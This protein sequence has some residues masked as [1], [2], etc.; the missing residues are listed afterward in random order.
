MHCRKSWARL[1]VAEK[2]AFI[3]AV[4]KLKND[5]AW[6]SVLHPGD[7]TRH[8][9]DDYV[10]LH[11][12]A[13]SLMPSWAHMAPAFFSWHRELMRHFEADLRTIDASVSIPYW[14]WS[15]FGGTGGPIFEADASSGLGTNGQAS[16]GKVLDG[17]FAFNAGQWTIRVKDASGNPSFLARRFGERADAPSLATIPN[18]QIAALNQGAYDAPPWDD[19]VAG[20][21]G[22]SLRI[23]VEYDLHNLVHRWLART[24]ILRSSPNDPIF[25]L[26]H[27]NIDRLWAVWQRQHPTLDPYLPASGAPTGHNAGDALIFHDATFPGVPWPGTVTSASVVNHHAISPGAYWYDDDPPDVVARTNSIAFTDIQEGVGGTP[28]TTY[29]AVVLEVVPGPCNAITLEIVAGPTAGLGTPLGTS[30]VIPASDD[31]TP[32]KGRLWISY[33]TSAGTIYGGS[34]A[35]QATSHNSAGDVVWTETWNVG[36]SANSVPH[37][38]S[39]VVLVLDRS[40]SMADDS[41][42]GQPKVTKLREA[43]AIFLDIMQEDDGI[44]IVRFDHE[45]DRLLDVTEVGPLPAVPGSGREAVASILASSN[46]AT[47]LDPRGATSVGGGVAEGRDALT[48]APVPAVP[49]GAFGLLVLTDGNENRPPSIDSVDMAGAVGADTFAIGFGTAG[50]VSEDALDKLTHHN[51]GYLLITGTI[52]QSERFLL[53]KYFLQ[54]QAGFTNAQIVADP[55]GELVLG[56]EH[57]IPFW[58]TEADAGADVLVLSVAPGLIDFTLETPSGDLIDPSTMVSEPAVSFFSRP[59]I[60][61]YRLTLPALGSAPGGSHGGQ[62]H[63][64]LRLDKRARDLDRETLA[65][66]G[67]GSLP[68]SVEVRAHSNLRFAVDA[69]QDDRQPGAMVKLQA[70][71]SEYDIPVEGRA[72]VWADV[73][74]PGG[75]VSTFTFDEVRG[76]QFEASF[77]TAKHGVYRILVRVRGTTLFGRTFTREQALSAS[78]FHKRDHRIDDDK[79]SEMTEKREDKRQTTPGEQPVL[80]PERPRSTRPE[81]R[82]DVDIQGIAELETPEPRSTTV[83][84]RMP[85][86]LFPTRAEMEANRGKHPMP[87]RRDDDD[88][89]G[90]GHDEG[91]H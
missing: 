72:R 8:R 25:W 82:G 52:T 62:W 9:Y 32:T 69:F 31:P 76:G 6:P 18:D 60:A 33:S 45:V 21:G 16:D 3:S 89:E 12:E 1:T 20:G 58:L 30:I 49:Y 39:A 83:R 24:M 2:Q 77:K 81:R 88:S 50:N 4:L 73:T 14:D 29:R 27:C 7:A 86:P 51:G 59:R 17:A 91:E 19:M 56:A 11:L 41:G 43:V 28:T 79:A 64:I 63:A 90:Q 10:E 26:H 61:W 46:P 48:S 35:V 5:A 84:E 15:L 53:S 57:R 37:Q 54:I 38:P 13:M 80:D 34:L 40:G 22:D 87:E 47:T 42:D 71:L 75:A 44:G 55:T 67:Q 36:V 68:Y 70:S 74:E 66:I 23:R 85:M 78:T 65:S